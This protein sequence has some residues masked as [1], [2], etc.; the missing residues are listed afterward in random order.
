MTQLL[1]G[2]KFKILE[3]YKSWIKIKND[4]DGYTGYILNKNF[5]PDQNNTHKVF[6]LSANLYSKPNEK[7]KLKKN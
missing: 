1:Y 2:E 5:Q 3:K 7:I 4:N 6:V